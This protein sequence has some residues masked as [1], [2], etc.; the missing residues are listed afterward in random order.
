MLSNEWHDRRSKEMVCLRPYFSVR[1]RL[2][3]SRGLVTY[4]FDQ[5][6]LR[7][8]IPE[9][10]RGKVAANLHAGHQGLDSML[11]RARQTVYWPGME[12]DLQHQRTACNTCNLHAP[13]QPAEPLVMSPPPEYPFQQTVVDLCQLERNVYLVYADRLTGW[14]EVAHLA[15]GAT[16]RAIRD[17]LRRNFMRWGA[18]E[19][20]STDGGTN[21]ISDDM[22]AFYERWGVQL[23]VSSA[24]Y[25][26]SNG[27]AEAAVK[28]AKRTLRDNVAA[29]GD[30][31]T[32]RTSMALLQYLNTPLREIDKS[33]AE[34]VLG[35]QLRGT[36]PTAR[37]NLLVN[38]TWGSTL[39]KRE[40]QMAQQCRRREKAYE[41]RRSFTPIV[42]GARVLIHNEA[43]GT[44]DRTGV[45]VEA[46]RYSQYL[47]RLDGSGRMS[48]R[49]RRHLRP[50]PVRQEEVED[51]LDT[52]SQAS[53]HG[54]PTPPARST[55]PPARPGARLRRP[56]KW[57]QD[58]ECE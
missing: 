29:D 11:R 22:R 42:V 21:L 55:T 44:W 43:S 57:L 40:R 31:A 27:R 33:P 10:I 46:R 36:V 14:I 50:A 17:E 30:L 34:L 54:P 38:E 4:S 9:S 47:V 23:R 3:A 32:D 56:P 13:A 25:P 35:R 18:P 15:D 12:G 5:S 52:S 48:L 7:L 58:Y 49:T 20:L 16:V 26:Q 8:V 45:V 19:Q 41:T 24:H 53:H 37:R 6:H 51:D 2:G 39:R 1:E 28:S